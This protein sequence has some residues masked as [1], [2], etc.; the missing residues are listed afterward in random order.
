M[1]WGEDVQAWWQ[2]DV[3]MSNEF[4]IKDLY[5]RISC[6]KFLGAGRVKGR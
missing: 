1:T 3:L 4:F 5:L 6:R 2:N